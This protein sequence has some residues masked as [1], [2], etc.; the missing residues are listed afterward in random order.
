MSRDEIRKLLG[1][2]ATG[3]LT[4]EE[5]DALFATA[6][7]DQELFEALMREEPLRELLQ[8]PRAKTRLMAALEPKPAGYLRWLRPAAWAVPAAGL[9]AILV[10]FVVQR[11]A[12]RPV[13]VAQAPALPSLGPVVPVPSP[14]PQVLEKRSLPKLARA[15]TAAPAAT[16]PKD[17]NEPAQTPLVVADQ[18]LATAPAP[19]AVP[20]PAP[21]DKEA[22]L[23]PPA[24]AQQVI[25]D[26]TGQQ[27]AAGVRFQA[28]AV[29]GFAA[30]QDARALFFGQQSAI[31][32]QT[33][34]VETERPPVQRIAAAPV[35]QLGLRYS[36]LRKLPN[37]QFAAVIPNEVLGATDQVELR[38]ESNDA[39][40]LSVFERGPDG[41]RPLTSGR[42]ER[43]TPFTVPVSGTLMFDSSGPKEL[44]LVFSR[45]PQQTPYPVPAARLDQVVNT[46]LAERL[47]Y[48]VSTAPPAPAQ[49]IAF[50]ITLAHK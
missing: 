29:G 2:Y 43:L 17:A 40:M 3:T 38:V 16:A 26:A 48:V 20:A 13:M 23:N 30:V 47:T 12:S 42:I 32:A 46:N 24:A 35:S 18:L 14:V 1:G 11:Q 8:D 45:Q 36:I 25:V 9:A 44:F 21:A 41:W 33:N 49:T 22:A 39:G 37:G 6:L 10:M 5:R 4:P 7:E 50:P 15:V 19:A 34:V 28:G 31:L 27:G